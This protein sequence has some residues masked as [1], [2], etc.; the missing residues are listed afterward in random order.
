MA[1]EI[2]CRRQLLTLISCHLPHAERKYLQIKAPEKRF[3]IAATQTGSISDALGMRVK[4]KSHHPCK[5]R[6]RL[7]KVQR[8]LKKN[9][10]QIQVVVFLRCYMNCNHSLMIHETENEERKK[11]LLTLKLNDDVWAAFEFFGFN[12]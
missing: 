6:F 5:K 9:Q 1:N 2:S 7:K 11:S 10:Q 8:N 4:I 12:I 3:I